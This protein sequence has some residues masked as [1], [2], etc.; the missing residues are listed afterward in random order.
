MPHSA[1]RSATHHESAGHTFRRVPRTHPDLKP[2][3][4][5]RRAGG[6]PPYRRPL[7][8]VT[9]ACA[10]LSASA[11]AMAR[12]QPA[13]AVDPSTVEAGLPLRRV[14]RDAHRAVEEFE[15]RRRVLL[16]V[17]FGGTGR[18]D[19]HIGRYCYWYDPDE[20]PGPPEPGRIAQL[21]EELLRSLKAAALAVPADGWVAGQRVRYALE[22]HDSAGA[23]DAAA[24]C[25]A[26]RWWCQALDG[27]ALHGTGRAGEADRA[28]SAAL[29]AM[30]ADT[31]CRWRD[32][33]RLLQGDARD[34]YRDRSC[35]SRRALEARFWWLAAPFWSRPGNDRRSE[36]FARLVLARIAADGA[37]PYGGRWTDDLQELLVRYGWPD[38]WSRR[39]SASMATTSPPAVIGHDPA[40]S[41]AWLPDSRLLGAPYDAVSDDWDLAAPAAVSRMALPYAR[42][43][44][45][46]ATSVTL[47]RRGD[48][49]LVLAITELP[50]DVGATRSG[51][52]ALVLASDTA[53][54]VVTR[55]ATPARGTGAALL[56]ATGPDRRMLVGIEL[57]DDSAGAARDRFAVAPPPLDR[58]FGLSDLLLYEP[59]GDADTT[60]DAAAAR[61]S[62]GL[63]LRSDHQLGVLWE[64]YGL[65]D[66]PRPVRM[67]L[68]L[69]GG[70]AGWF[71]RTWSRLRGRARAATPLHMRWTDVPQ[72]AGTRSRAVLLGLPSL[73]AGDYTLELTAT[74]PD[75]RTAVATRALH[76]R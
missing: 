67:E 75:G 74:A 24:S 8:L 62:T 21:R 59:R 73:R 16:P 71:T 55:V 22:A 38:R 49:L 30:P 36:H 46:L 70:R 11:P 15:R 43:I 47:L 61:P 41:Q 6:R 66:G 33:S 44:S 3:G 57:L 17:T 25:A 65:P 5:P 26:E 40:P 10:A 27:L 35:E 76:V 13:R 2:P 68:A 54:I 29:A 14:V 4:A 23:R 45:P 69:H 34:R 50:D 28:F 18:C 31:A 56:Q 12:A 7:A 63:R 42:H 53:S 51:T 19:V 52:V 1:D 48:S 60:L 20:P 32:L 9:A 58:G 37:T 72:G 39:E 64:L